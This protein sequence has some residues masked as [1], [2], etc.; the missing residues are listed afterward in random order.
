VPYESELPVETIDLP[1]HHTQDREGIMGTPGQRPSAAMGERVVDPVRRMVDEQ[2]AA[3][4]AVR[5]GEMTVFFLIPDDETFKPV[6]V[7][8]SNVDEEEAKY[9]VVFGGRYPDLLEGAEQN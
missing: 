6:K 5:E 7:D 8:S 2:L 4:Q 1:F 9:R 3:M